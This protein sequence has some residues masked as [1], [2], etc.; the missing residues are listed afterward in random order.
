M[1]QTE[2]HHNQ[3]LA[4]HLQIRPYTYPAIFSVGI[5]VDKGVVEAAICPHILRVVV[6][7]HLRRFPVG[8]TIDVVTSIDDTG[9]LNETRTYKITSAR[10]F[11]FVS[12]LFSGLR[13]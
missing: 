6:P 9:R 7:T 10:R 13:I 1:F 12:I 4:L 3:Q 8:I 2:F 5:V 11:F